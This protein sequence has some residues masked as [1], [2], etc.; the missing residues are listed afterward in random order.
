[1]S[2]EAK[3]LREVF[4]AIFK[5]LTYINRDLKKKIFHFLP[6]ITHKKHSLGDLPENLWKLYFSTKFQYKEIS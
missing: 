6:I 4:Q 3:K 5:T 1:M 2:I